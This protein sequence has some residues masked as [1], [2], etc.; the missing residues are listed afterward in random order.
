MEGIGLL[1]ANVSSINGPVSTSEFS[2]LDRLRVAMHYGRLCP[3]LTKYQGRQMNQLEHEATQNIPEPKLC[4][5][6]IGARAM[7]ISIGVFYKACR[8]KTIPSYRFGRKVLVNIE[9]IMAA[10][11]SQ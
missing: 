11:R 7:G 9:E 2:T 4:H 8:L 3:S 6:K 10:M 5:A 1:K